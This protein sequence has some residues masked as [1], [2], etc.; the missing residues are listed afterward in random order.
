MLA[1]YP[2]KAAT[3]MT[4]NDD[5]HKLFKEAMQSVRPLK[6][7]DNVKHD[8]TPLKPRLMRQEPIEDAPEH[9]DNSGYS[10]PV[11][12]DETIS[13]RREDISHKAFNR[14]KRGQ[15]SMEG[16]LDLHGYTIE[17]AEQALIHFLDHAQGTGKRCLLIVHGKG[18]STPNQ[19]PVLKNK[20]NLWLRNRPDVLAFCSAQP[21]NGGAGA[22]Y[23]WLAC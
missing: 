4:T 9:L 23:L 18:Y 22:I 10:E 20:V 6:P 8:Q 19:M 3:S 15:R 12:G 11:S 7:Q 1:L 5:D 14:L 13:Y 21:R 17:E 2:V 16:K